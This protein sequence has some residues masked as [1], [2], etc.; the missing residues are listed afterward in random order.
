ML[1]EGLRWW[2]IVAV[3]AAGVLFHGGHQRR[4]RQERHVRRTVSHRRRIRVLEVSRLPNSARERQ[5][6]A[7]LGGAA[8]CVRRIPVSQS[9][10]AAV[11]PVTKR[12]AR[13]GVS[14]WRGQRRSRDATA[15]AGDDRARGCGTWR[16]GIC[17]D[18]AL[19]GRGRGVCEP[20]DLRLL[21][22]NARLRRAGNLGHDR[23]AVF[24]CH[25]WLHLDGAAPRHVEDFAGQLLGRWPGCSSPSFRRRWWS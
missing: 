16:A 23:R 6:A 5:P 21:P 11:A 4:G 24:H 13:A 22:D 10:C 14:V 15:C 9:R 12:N 20:D 17:L 1:C 8:A 18:S 19:A 25:G 3:G 7:A 2:Q